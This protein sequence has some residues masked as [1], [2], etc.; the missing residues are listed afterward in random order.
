M[1]PFDPDAPA[2]PAGLGRAGVADEEQLRVEAEIP[3][4]NRGLEPAN[5]DGA[6][7]DLRTLRADQRRHAVGRLAGLRIDADHGAPRVV[8]VEAHAGVDVELGRRPRPEDGGELGTHETIGPVAGIQRVV[9][10]DVELIGVGAQ[11]Q[12]RADRPR[13]FDLALRVHADHGLT[14]L[15]PRGSSRAVAVP[16][17]DRGPPDRASRAA[18]ARRWRSR[19]AVRRSGPAADR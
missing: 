15:G 14:D 10:R 4:G 13:P 3:Q 12:R 1:R 9:G 6:H 17:C 7:A 11:A 2:R 18:A 8:A 16:L 5:A 19:C